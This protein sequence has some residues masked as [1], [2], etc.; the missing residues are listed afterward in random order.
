MPDQEE[1]GSY[2]QVRVRVNL[3][4]S[5]YVGYVRVYPPKTRV[6][7]V[8]NEE[9]S[10]MSLFDV[11]SVDPITEGS[12]LVVHKRRVSYI[13]AIE[14]FTRK[15]NTKV[16]AGGFVEVKIRLDDFV[17]GGTV[18]LPE[19]LMKSDRS[20]LLGVNPHFLNVKG[21]SVIGTNERYN[22]LAVSKNQIRSIEIKG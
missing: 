19:G 20:A 3:S 16:H 22:F 6:S 14:E 21:V 17:I 1:V 8:L 15:Y 5:R 18:F 9:D 10:F 11:D 7:D 2:K 4:G 12:Q 13:Q